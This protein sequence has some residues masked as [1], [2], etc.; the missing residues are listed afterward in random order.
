LLTLVPVLVL[1]LVLVLVIVLI[2]QMPN[3][4]FEKILEK[5]GGQVSV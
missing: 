5:F 2:R 1:V 3:A 4:R